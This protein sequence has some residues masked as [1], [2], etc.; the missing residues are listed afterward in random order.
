MT[1][2]ECGSVGVWEMGFEFIGYSHSGGDGDADEVA[3]FYVEAEAG[4]GQ[5]GADLVHRAGAEPARVGGQ[6]G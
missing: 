1:D 6:G 2:G 3:V 5:G 4:A